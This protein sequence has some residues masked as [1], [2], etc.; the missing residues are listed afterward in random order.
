MTQNNNVKIAITGGIGSG[1]STVSKIISESGFKV[2]SCDKIYSELLHEKNFLSK[3]E[4]EFGDILLN[5]GELDRKKL[6]SIVFS[7]SEKLLKLNEIT[8]PE[9]IRRALDKMTDGGISFCEVPLLFENGF[10][11][12]FNNAIVVLRDKNLRINS[13]RKRDKLS[14][15]AINLR[16]KSQYDYDYNVFTQYYVIHNNTNME[17]L[18]SDTL[19]IIEKI[20]KD[21]LFL[22]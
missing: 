5:N 20:K 12:F 19:K 21:Y 6:A 22:A 1:K 10:E 11:R 18:Y 7:D 2:Y 3:L 13:V 16:I 14:E 15:N 9:I 8:H 17:D 4:N